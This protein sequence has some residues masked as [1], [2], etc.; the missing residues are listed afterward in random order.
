MT[1][2]LTENYRGTFDGSLGLGKAPALI[3]VDFVEAYF[4]TQ[5]PFYA[6][7]ESALASALRLRDA[8]RAAGIPVI[9]TNV[10]YQPGGADGGVFYRK[11]PALKVF[12]EGS[13]L[14]GWPA[15]LEPGEGEVVLSKQY[16][17]AFFGT[18]LK[19][20]LTGQGA[21]TLIMTGVTT[22]GCI[23]ATRKA[24]SGAA[25]A[26]AST[27]SGASTRQRSR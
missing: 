3:L 10:V 4:D 8:A 24:A 6:G 15:G 14:G 18:D 13:P 12:D 26:P 1:D 17:S 23:R 2:D 16:P 22:S 5:S 25:S 7:V 19:E 9:Y 20:L 11:L 27:A 21:D